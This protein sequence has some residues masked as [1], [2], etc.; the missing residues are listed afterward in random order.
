M[1]LF[2]ERVVNVY[3]FIGLEDLLEYSN[4]V[5]KQNVMKVIDDV[6]NYLNENDKN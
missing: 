2:Q 3:F 5:R 1:I 4:I 6:Y